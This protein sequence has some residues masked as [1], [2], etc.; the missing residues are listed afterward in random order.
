MIESKNL[1][2]SVLEENPY[3]DYMEPRISK[4]EADAILEKMLNKWDD[5]GEGDDE[6]RNEH[7]EGKEHPK[8]GVPFER[9]EVEVNGEKREVVVPK[10]ES[11]FDAQ[12]PEELYEASDSKQF[13]E[14]NKQLK[15][16]IENNQDLREQ[17]D[18]EQL[19]QIENGDTPDG[20]TW[21]H[22]AEAGKMQLVDTETHQKTGHT[23]GRVIWGGGNENR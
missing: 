7:L 5:A 2:I 6:W 17:F 13:E 16:A 1:E 11:K 22:D 12:L 3:I 21:H 20:Y 8:T 19:E 23:G 4:E 10:F 15:E 9:K 14:C 18:A